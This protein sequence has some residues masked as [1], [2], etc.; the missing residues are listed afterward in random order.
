MILML[1]LVGLLML[2]ALAAAL[3]KVWKLLA[4]LLAL[5]G[6]MAVGVVL[7]MTVAALALS[8]TIRPTISTPIVPTHSPSTHAT[9]KTRCRGVVE[10]VTWRDAKFLADEAVLVNL[11]ET[12]AETQETRLG[13]NFS[14]VHQHSPDGHDCRSWRDQR[15]TTA[16]ESSRAG[17]QTPFGRSRY[18]G[19]THHLRYRRWL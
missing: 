11:A 3:A 9:A 12:V 7:V 17:N 15:A 6:A 19:W 14:W 16:R 1:F 5:L 8:S 13:P 10:S 4:S 2:S 18:L